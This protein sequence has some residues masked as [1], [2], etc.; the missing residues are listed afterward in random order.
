MWDFV[1]A[2]YLLSTQ[3]G[4]FL[5][6]VTWGMP[7]QTSYSVTKLCLTLY[8]SMN[9]STPGFPV[10]H[11]LSEFTKTHVHWVGDAIQPPNPL[12]L[13]FPLA[14]SLCQH[15]GLFH[16]VGSSYQVAKVLEFQHQF[17][18]I[19]EYPQISIYTLTN[20]WYFDWL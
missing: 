13:P 19:L 15:Q 16:R 2:S 11:Y 4:I 9:C 7:S 20:G 3:S 1:S 12:P 14:L 17:L 10:F 5:R 6:S 18:R 8:V